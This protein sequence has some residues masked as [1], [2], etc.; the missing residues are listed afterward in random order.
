MN[1][2]VCQSRALRHSLRWKHRC[3]GSGRGVL[4]RAAAWPRGGRLLCLRGAVVGR[5][6]DPGLERS[7][8]PGTDTTAQMHG[9]RKQSNGDPPV[10]RRSRQ[11]R[12]CDD[13][14]QAVEGRY[15]V[16]AAWTVVENCK[17]A[18]HR[19][20]CGGDAPWELRRA[21]CRRCNDAEC[22]RG[23]GND[24]CRGVR[25]RRTRF[26]ARRSPSTARSR[27][28]HSRI[29]E[30]RQPMQRPRNRSLR[31]RWPSRLRPTIIQ[32]GRR[33]S[34]ATSCA[35]NNSCTG[36]YRS[37]THREIDTGFLLAIGLEFG[38]D[39][40]TV[41]LLVTDGFL[42]CESSAPRNRLPPAT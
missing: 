21:R 12:D 5:I 36:G 41:A 33:V 34:R 8:R 26:A 9:T 14:A 29:S 11:R 19:L 17:F 23:K 28:I 38:S 1:R 7:P 40:D 6:G 31:G 42:G 37:L 27:A 25:R 15:D 3:A 20:M 4:P 35:L 39:T 18:T 22:A 32:H 24:A 10:E 13:I 30:R 16:T 2:C